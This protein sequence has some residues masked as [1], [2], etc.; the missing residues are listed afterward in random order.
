VQTSGLRQKRGRGVACQASKFETLEGRQL[1]SVGDL[2]Q[3]PALFLDIPG[4]ASATSVSPGV[5]RLDIRAT[6]PSVIDTAGVQSTL[7]PPAIAEI[8]VLV[9][10]DG[11]LNSG[12][13]GDDLHVYRD[14]DNNG[15]FSAGDLMLISGE[16]KANGTGFKVAGVTAE[17]IFALN[18]T[19]AWASDPLYFKGLSGPLDAGV[20]LDLTGPGGAPI[21]FA[22]EFFDYQPKG[23]L[24]AVPPPTIDSWSSLAG[25]VFAECNDNG[26]FEPGEKEVG[27]PGVTVTLLD[28]ANNV[29]ATDVTDA[30]G[31]YSFDAL[32]PGTY[33]IVQS[34]P[35]SYIDGKDTVGTVSGSPRGT[36]PPAGNDRI[37]EI[38]LAGAEVGIDY[39]FA[40]QLPSSLSGYVYSDVNCNGVIDSFDGPIPDVCITLKKSTGETW[41]TTTDKNG[42]YKFAALP[43]GN[44]T[45]IETQPSGVAHGDTDA[46]S[47][48]GTANDSASNVCNIRV[49]C[50]QEGIC[51]NFGE[52]PAAIKSGQTTT[53]AWWKGASGMALIKSL[54]G[55]ASST[56]LGN[57]LAGNFPN[58]FGVLAGKTNTV[59]A[60]YF[61]AKLSSPGKT[62]ESRV[63]STALSCYTTDKGLGGTA[64]AKYGAK[65]DDVGLGGAIISLG[66]N[67]AAFGFKSGTKTT[68][69]KL[70]QRV[71]QAAWNGVLW[72]WNKNGVADISGSNAIET[73]HRKLADAIFAS[74]SK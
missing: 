28:A 13:T 29:V 5:K 39:T 36:L 3:L 74:V 59:V 60:D 40:E 65:I 49:K 62:L 54:N 53:L 71:D 19:G 68:I 8:S 51:Y 6:G 35:A 45:I 56:A 72:D 61:L 11:S 22:T 17:F 44:Y 43:A 7:T 30:D 42:F 73:T 1:F 50:G 47:L 25:R 55:G 26:N 46:G 21:S 32:V 69:F 48:G 57:W 67:A 14:N 10:D 20:Q 31:I 70:L 52:K 15:S 27:I 2:L 41:K 58:L 23:V 9:N 66:S 34:Q 24:G 12:V 37:A 4:T 64:A 38:T 18:N 33:T 16:I 63:L